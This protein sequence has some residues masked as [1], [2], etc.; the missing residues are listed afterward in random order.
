[1]K[2]F[3]KR[4]AVLLVVIL[5][6]VS[7][8]SVS[9]AKI[10]NPILSG[11][12]DVDGEIDAVW[13]SATAIQL[14]LHKVGDESKNASGYAKMLWDDKFLYCIGVV[15]DNTL[16]K[17]YRNKDSYWWHDSFE[18]FVDEAN[19]RVDKNS[20]A[21]FRVDVFGKFTGMLNDTVLDEAGMRAKY[22]KFKGA[23]K[24]NANGYVVEMAMPWTLISPKGDTSKLGI[25]FQINDD[26]DS[27]G[28]NDGIINSP[29]PNMWNPMLYPVF[30]LSSEKAETQEAQTPSKN[31]TASKNDAASKNETTSN[32]GTVSKNE[33]ASKGDVASKN[34]TTDKTDKNDN[35]SSSVT[36]DS[37]PNETVSDIENTDDSNGDSVEVENETENNKTEE[38]V[39]V[40]YV[41]EDNF[42]ANAFMLII[43]GAVIIIC[44]IG[45]ILVYI[46][47]LRAA[48]KK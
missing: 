6:V 26:Q 11:T 16:T 38:N 23:S 3:L 28:E 34:E 19:A 48:P 32:Q 30:T 25:A 13:E 8:F 27:K 44:L 45:T 43:L 4:A 18:F 33:T 31:E 14:T 35:T 29:V 12:V 2:T 9:A 39:R 47:V 42:D 5:V 37:K 36:T 22:P 46:F 21:Q 40:E 7:S 20:I 17:S 1:M 24:K 15:T 10:K 41:T